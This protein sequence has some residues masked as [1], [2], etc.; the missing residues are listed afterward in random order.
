MFGRT[1]PVTRA[2]HRRRLAAALLI[3]TVLAMAA[4][5][6][7][8][9]RPTS[10]PTA[11]AVPSL[12]PP[13]AP[14]TPI[15][16]AP[17]KQ[18]VPLTSP[19][20]DREGGGAAK[21]AWSR[22]VAEVINW[23]PLIVQSRAG[24]R[25]VVAAEPDAVVALDPADGRE[26]W[27]FG[28]GDR[29]WADTVM[30]V[31][32]GVFVGSAGGQALFLDGAT[33]EVR[34]QVDL[35]QADDPTQAGLEARGRPAVAGNTLYVPTAGV[36]SRAITV[37]PKLRAPLVALDLATGQERWR[38]P[39]ANYILRSPVVD[40]AAETV[41]VGGVR[42]AEGDV[43]EGGQQSIYALSTADGRV[44]WVY[45]SLDGL[46]KSLWAGEDRLVFVAYRDFIVG[47][48]AESG[49]EVWRV[50]SGNWVQSLTALPLAD[51]G[52]GP[53]IA[54]GSANGFLNLLRPSDGG[55]LWRFDL[56]GTFNYPM[57]NAVES[58]GVIYFIT[59][60]GDLYALEAA[61]GRLRWMVPTGLESRDGVAVGAG[62]LFVGDARGAI[63]AF[64]LENRE[65]APLPTSGSLCVVCAAVIPRSSGWQ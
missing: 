40:R 63:H 16:G 27:R 39:T 36:G 37:N 52:N 62:R 4:C 7:P 51:A 8:T 42:Q 25:V 23:A 3:L 56:P 45:D 35:Q 28:P 26:V 61:S 46:T 9:A 19:E 30:V 38:T 24:E 44:Q 29:L 21:L 47:V 58:G 11:P 17:T 59:Q 12:V 2:V 10:P 50:N 15:P 33:G 41:Y 32:D 18:P 43:D 5:D 20:P 14:T 34:W 48:D 54:F 57:G 49:Q 22:S 1:T 53:A 13:V 6:A 64:D 65:S 55:E 31:G 60:Q